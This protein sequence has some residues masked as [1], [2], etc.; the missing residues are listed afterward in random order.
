M[1]S[2]TSSCLTKA[3]Q[4]GLLQ[5]TQYTMSC[6]LQSQNSYDFGTTANKNKRV[7]DPILSV[8]S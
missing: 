5:A 2:L 3:D 4:G 8:K 7:T 1:F 6:L